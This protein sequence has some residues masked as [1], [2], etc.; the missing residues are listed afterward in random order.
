MERMKLFWSVFIIIVICGLVYSFPP[1]STG[2][3]IVSSIGAEPYSNAVYMGLFNSG[4]GTQYVNIRAPPTIAGTTTSSFS[5]SDTFSMKIHPTKNIAYVMA[6]NGANGPVIEVVN[7]KTNQI[8]QKI[9]P[10]LPG[11]YG[12]QFALSHDGTKIA[13]LI[14]DPSTTQVILYQ[15]NTATY[16]VQWVVLTSFTGE[17]SIELKYSDDDSILYSQVL[18]FTTNRIEAYTAT[19]GQLIITTPSTIFPLGDGWFMGDGSYVTYVHHPATGYYADTT[20]L[21]TGGVGSSLLLS[22]GPI[23]EVVI[24][25]KDN[26][27]AVSHTGTSVIDDI[28]IVKMNSGGIVNMC[29]LM[30]PPPPGFGSTGNFKKMF[31]GEKTGMLYAIY[32]QSNGRNVF[33]IDP[34]NC[35]IKKM[36]NTSAT[37]TIDYRSQLSADERY[38]IN[39]TISGQIV[40]ADF[41]TNQIVAVPLPGATLWRT[42]DVDFIK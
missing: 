32:D 36:Y 40:F 9:L 33:Q 10:A 29:S 28:D 4:T 27:L 18:H 1:G 17:T 14:V 41:L 30:I 37:Y 22:P 20:D 24:N 31:F 38:V 2:F 11:A 26:I 7:T 25:K 12:N 23:G 39:H 21:Q 5:A 16:T 15:L 3:P 19:N 42:S 34:R 13:I 8:I 35:Q 6:N